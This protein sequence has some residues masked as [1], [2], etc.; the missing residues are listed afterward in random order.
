[1]LRPKPLFGVGVYILMNHF[2]GANDPVLINRTPYE[3]SPDVIG[4][5]F[6][7]AHMH[8]ISTACSS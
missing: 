6:P 7:M 2:Q 3:R 5:E 4:L 8:G 1:V